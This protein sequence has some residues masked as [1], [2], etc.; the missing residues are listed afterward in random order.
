MTRMILLVD[1]PDD[2]A[3]GITSKI[4]DAALVGAKVAIDFGD[5]YRYEVDALPIPEPEDYTFV[6]LTDND[7]DTALIACRGKEIAE[8][9]AR[10]AVFNDG[11]VS[12]WLVPNTAL[13]QPSVV[14]DAL[15]GGAA[16]RH[17]PSGLATS[18]VYV[19]LEHP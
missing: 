19:S 4:E 15:E 9:V 7:N 10:A 11:G 18:P 2:D 8:S 16:I 17:I 14:Q 13:V 6:L 1:V 5:G 3:D 12:A